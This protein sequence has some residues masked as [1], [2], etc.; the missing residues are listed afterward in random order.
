MNTERIDQLLDK[1]FDGDTSLEEEKEL[2]EFFRQDDIPTHL[3]SCADQFS[4]MNT[5][6]TPKTDIDPFA[7]IEGQE[8]KS[9]VE[10]AVCTHF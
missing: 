9:P 7:K 6:A 2:R 3:K 1:Y 4:Y 10:A 8:K 5:M